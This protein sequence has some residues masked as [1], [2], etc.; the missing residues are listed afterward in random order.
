[1]VPIRTGLPERLLLGFAGGKGKSQSDEAGESAN[2]NL[3]F[4]V[5]GRERGWPYS[6]TSSHRTRTAE[7]R[8][9]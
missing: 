2:E 8:E 7:V 1:V 9:S 3:H 4:V 5:W 6:S